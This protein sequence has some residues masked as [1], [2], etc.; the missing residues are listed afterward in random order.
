MELSTGAPGQKA[1]PS[2]VQSITKTAGLARDLGIDLQGGDT[3]VVKH[4]GTL[5]SLLHKGDW[6]VK[7]YL[8]DAYF[9][10]P[11]SQEHRR[12]LCFQVEEKLYQFT[13]LPFGLASAQ[14]VFTK[15]LKPIVALR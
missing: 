3:G 15:T 2:P 4:A 11:V 8:M 1:T 5:K 6:L 9:S 12:F 13:G 7:I 10:V 14:W